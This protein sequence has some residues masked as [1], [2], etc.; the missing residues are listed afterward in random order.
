MVPD[1]LRPQEIESTHLDRV[2]PE[3]VLRSARSHV[4]PWLNHSDMPRVIWSRSGNPD[5]VVS[6]ILRIERWQLRN[7]LHRIKEDAG[8]T[9]LTALLYGTTAQSPIYRVSQLGTSTTASKADDTL[10]AYA[11]LRFAGDELDPSEISG[12]L[13]V[14]PTRAYRKGE[15]YFAGPRT[16]KITGRT[17]IWLL[18]T[19]GVVTG[20]D[21]DQH[22]SYLFKLIFE[23]NGDRSARLHKLIADRGL[24]GRVSCFWHGEAGAHPPKIPKF[25]VDAFER[26]PA[27]IET[28]FDTD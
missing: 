2:A 19:D 20:S 28:D 5:R 16:G 17:G 18:S 7:A 12:L 3:F 24:K 8:L 1:Q 23:H 9:A 25:A 15:R 10:K 11:I 13:G 21:L 14:N 27:D 4:K 22:I 26:L 6:E